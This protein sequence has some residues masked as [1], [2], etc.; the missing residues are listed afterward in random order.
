MKKMIIVTVVAVA[1]VATP[2]HAF[3]E[4]KDSVEVKILDIGEMPKTAVRQQNAHFQYA[5]YINVDKLASGEGE[6]DDVR[7]V[8]LA[9]ERTGTVIKVCVTNP[10]AEAQWSKMSGKVADGVSVPLTQIAAADKAMIVPG[11]VSKV[12]VEGCPDGRNIWTYIID[13]Y[14]GTA[15]QLPSTE[16]VVRLD[17]EK[18]EIIAASYGYDD[19][20]RYS[21]NKAYSPDG[22]FL[23]RIGEKER[24]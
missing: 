24:E 12:I 1:F 16:G 4:S 8:W 14:Q 15:I 18:K 17:W 19:D 10:M 9:D 3:A 23:R 6:M 5:V 2:I 20:G 13:P 21:V 11:D 7:S 22:K